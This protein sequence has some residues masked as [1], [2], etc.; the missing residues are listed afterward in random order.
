MSSAGVR[1]S[2]E[3]TGSCHW[4]HRRRS[5]STRAVVSPLRSAGGWRG[6]AQAGIGCSTTA[7]DHTRGTRPHTRH[8][9]GVQ[10]AHGTAHRSIPSHPSQVRRGFR[11]LDED[12]SGTL[13][14][15]EMRSVLM[16]FN[17]D[18]EARLIEK[19]IDFA[20]QARCLPRLLRHRRFLRHRLV[21]PA[22]APPPMAPLRIPCPSPRPLCRTATAPSTTPSSRA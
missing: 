17:L 3:G 19:L 16:M 4:L 14:R 2:S 8:T 6:R 1:R 12:K 15:Q 5:S 10:V 18:I 13:T 7:H 20:D 22:A 9:R 11:L 21:W